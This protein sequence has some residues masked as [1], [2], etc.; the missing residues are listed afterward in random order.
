GVSGA[1]SPTRGPGG[2]RPKTRAGER[3]IAGP[4]P[5]RVAG[6]RP[7]S[8]DDLAALLLALGLGHRD[9]ALALARVLA[10]AAVARAGAG[11]V[12][13]ALVD[14]DTL[15]LVRS[16]LVLPHGLGGA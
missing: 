7:G 8:A 9:D 4:E 3:R 12:A 10:G 14:A 6:A 5:R 13:L 15:D 16:R 11:A 1:G 2:G